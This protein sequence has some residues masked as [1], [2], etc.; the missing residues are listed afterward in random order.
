MELRIKAVR[1]LLSK[2]MSDGQ[3]MVLCKTNEMLLISQ[4][5]FLCCSLCASS[6]FLLFLMCSYHLSFL[7]LTFC[8]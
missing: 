6:L 4:A 2:G 1:V 8:I 7:S 3:I 5:V